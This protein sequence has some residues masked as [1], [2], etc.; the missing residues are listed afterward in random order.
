MQR[1][2]TLVFLSVLM[3]SAVLALEIPDYDSQAPL[4]S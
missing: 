1:I 2:A 4:G 3:P